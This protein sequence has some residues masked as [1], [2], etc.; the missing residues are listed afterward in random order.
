[1]EIIGEKTEVADKVFEG[2]MK[3]NLQSLM[4]IINLKI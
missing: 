1:M 4:I 3:E 2:I